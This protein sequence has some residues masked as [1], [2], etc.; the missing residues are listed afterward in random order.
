M[1]RGVS[2][3]AE[4]KQTQQSRNDSNSLGNLQTNQQKERGIFDIQEV[5]MDVPQWTP[6]SAYPS[7]LT[8][9]LY[10]GVTLANIVN[11][12]RW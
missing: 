11:S 3:C 8:V 2:T 7:L 9:E 10:T 6:C 1:C 4:K 5:A 12:R